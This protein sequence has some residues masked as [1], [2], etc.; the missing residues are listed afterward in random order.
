M[1]NRRLLQSIGMAVVAVAVA[2][3]ILGQGSGTVTAQTSLP[4]AKLCTG[5]N[6][7]GT[8]IAFSTDIPDLGATTIRDGISSANMQSGTAISFY[9]EY[10][11]MGQCWTF[12]GTGGGFPDLRDP[13]AALDGRMPADNQARSVR[14]GRGCPGWAPSVTLYDLPNFDG[15]ALSTTA[16]ITSTYPLGFDDRASSLRVTGGI[17]VAVYTGYGAN[18]G[19]ASCL[20][21]RGSQATL[22]P[23]FDGAVRSL[24][25]NYS[26]EQGAV[27]P[28]VAMPWVRLSNTDNGTSIYLTGDTSG[29]N[30]NEYFNDVTDVVTA[31]AIAP[32]AVY[33]DGGFGGV[34]QEIPAG[35]TLNLNGRLINRNAV[36]SVRIDRRCEGGTTSP[37]AV[38]L[39]DAANFQGQSL[40]LTEATPDLNSR[41][42]FGRQASSLKLVNGLKV[43]AVYSSHDY[44]GL[45]ETFAVQDPWLGDNFIGNDAIVSV[46]PGWTCAGP[47]VGEVA[48]TGLKLTHTSNCPAGY[49]RRPMDLNQ[50]VGGNYIFLCVQ[51]GARGDAGTYYTGL[52]AEAVSWN[53]A[54]SGDSAGTINDVVNICNE[55]ATIKQWEVVTTAGH[56]GDA[57]YADLN[58]NSASARGS[59]FFCATRAQRSGSLA[60]NDEYNPRAGSLKDVRFITYQGDPGATSQTMQTRRD[61]P[62]TACP[63]AYGTSANISWDD[64]DLNF[65]YQGTHT[66]IQTCMAW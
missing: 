18:Q 8:C 33:S 39:L 53:I 1:R 47:V 16:S 13:T 25:L 30:I 49:E 66:V 26:C 46:R 40:Y 29:L 51:Y 55:P 17:T 48:I 44:Q 43:A 2:A 37:P 63:G 32:V 35:Q 21:V 50:S 24:R 12:V 38:Q 31:S 62:T 27:A 19:G 6:F 57:L 59:V 15:D 42:L 10:K 52:R 14:Y 34:C 56:S 9:S 22:P 64:S 41:L 23:G 65:G 60:L 36:S 7:G 20:T 4:E 11:F 5:Y 45:C 3:G 54:S 28:P 61:N 58:A